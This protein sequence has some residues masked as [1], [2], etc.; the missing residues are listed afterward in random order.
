MTVQ[1]QSIIFGS[2]FDTID[3]VVSLQEAAEVTPGNMNKATENYVAAAKTGNA[4]VANT[5]KSTLKFVQSKAA[6][7][8]AEKARTENKDVL[9]GE[10]I[11]NVSE[12]SD[13]TSFAEKNLAMKQ[14]NKQRFQDK[15]KQ[16][17]MQDEKKLQ[18][19][20][21]QIDAARRRVDATKSAESSSEEVNESTENQIEKNDELAKNATKEVKAINGEDGIKTADEDKN[22]SESVED[23]VKVSARRFSK[24]LFNGSSGDALKYFIY[25]E[26]TEGNREELKI[27]KK[28]RADKEVSAVIKKIEYLLR[29][30]T[31]GNFIDNDYLEL[32]VCKSKFRQL[33]YTFKK[34]N[35]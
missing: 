25:G 24:M 20:D 26:I 10:K 12:A 8:A 33:F 30:A 27:A 2:V 23:P 6:V 9:S 17:R 21:A 3:D 11:K 22:L 19:L 7:D 13:P 35:K 1:E 29:K 14:A 32:K 18:A 15:L 34:E 16:D 28:M 5:A 31:S 4:I